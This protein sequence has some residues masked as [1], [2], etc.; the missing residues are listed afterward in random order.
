M[1]LEG[2]SNEEKKD[3]EPEFR[4]FSLLQIEDEEMDSQDN[5]A[6]EDSEVK[7]NS[8]VLSF[9]DTEMEVDEGSRGLQ[10]DSEVAGVR[11]PA[12]AQKKDGCTKELVG[13]RLDSPHLEEDL[14]IGQVRML[15]PRKEDEFEGRFH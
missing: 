13:G 4:D 6:E 14:G 3:N 2:D 5:I 9:I 1:A 12:L 10:E 7:Q 11:D 8:R 15:E